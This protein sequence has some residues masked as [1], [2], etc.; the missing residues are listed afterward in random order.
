[1]SR[2]PKRKTAANRSQTP[3]R[4]LQPCDVEPSIP[5]G[6]HAMAEFVRLVAELDRRGTLERHD[7][8]HIT[9]AA[10]VWGRLYAALELNDEKI[11]CLLENIYRGYKRELGLT[12]LPSRSIVRT[13][14]KD[15]NQYPTASKIKIHSD[16]A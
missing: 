1:M 10:R 9:A 15:D 12:S 6:D 16:T 13:V 2:G 14:A 5:L 3:P 4:A 8:G 7:V 11:A